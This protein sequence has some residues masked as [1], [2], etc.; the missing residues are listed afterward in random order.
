MASALHF[1]MTS[2]KIIFTLVTLLFQ[3]H[4]NKLS[5]KCNMMLK[6]KH[7]WPRKR[8]SYCTTVI[9]FLLL[10]HAPRVSN[11]FA[12]IVQSSV[13]LQARYLKKKKK[14]QSCINFM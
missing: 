9:T 10:L 13:C 2:F 8:D 3:E 4:K 14:L 6:G 1:H 5:F 11:I 12:P 7:L